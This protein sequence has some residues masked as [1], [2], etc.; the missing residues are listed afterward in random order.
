MTCL[1]SLSQQPLWKFLGAGCFDH[2]K[3]QGDS[4]RISDVHTHLSKGNNEHQSALLGRGRI[5]VTLCEEQ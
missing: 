4:V 1:T 3:V 2:M 5:E